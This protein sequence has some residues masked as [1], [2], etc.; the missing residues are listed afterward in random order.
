MS[1]QGGALLWKGNWAMRSQS[2]RISEDTGIVTSTV[3]FAIQNEWGVF[4]G[5][6][7]TVNPDTGVGSMNRGRASQAPWFFEGL[8]V[9]SDSDSYRFSRAQFSTCEYA[10]RD[11]HVSA[12][13]LEFHPEKWFSAW[14]NVLYL[15]PC[16]LFY[17]PYWRQSLSSNPNSRTSVSMDYDK[18]NGITVNTDT[19]IRLSS[20]VYD[21]FLADLYSRQGVGV[22]D[23]LDYNVKGLGRGTLYGY[24]V[25]EHL[26][27]RRRWTANSS[28]WMGLSR[29]YSL[30]WRLAAMSDPAFNTDYYRSNAAAV[31]AYLLNSAAVVRQSSTTTT[32]LSFS[33]QDNLNPAAPDH[34]IKGSEDYPRLDFNTSS[35]KLRHLPGLSQFTAFAD[36]NYTNGQGFIQDSAGGSWNWTGNLKLARG[37]T[38]APAGTLSETFQEHVSTFN[39]APGLPSHNVLFGRYGAAPDLRV[40]TG[41]GDWDLR[42]AYTCRLTPNRFTADTRAVDHGV[43]QNLASLSDSLRPWRAARLTVSSGYDLRQPPAGAPAPSLRERVLPLTANFNWQ[44]RSKVDISVSETYRMGFRPAEANQSTTL[45]ADYGEPGS[46]HVGLGFAKNSATPTQTQ[47][48]QSAGYWPRGLSWS[49]EASAHENL[50]AGAGSGPGLAKKIVSADARLRKN[51]HDFFGEVGVLYR[52][53]GV[54]QYS[55]DFHLR[56]REA[57]PKTIAHPDWE[58]EWYPWRNPLVPH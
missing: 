42:Y 8:R 9:D 52:P 54:L 7:G 50:G 43:E 57:A 33:R 4:S 35:L 24:Y 10:P 53:G 18:R 31:S 15:G 29:L 47:I 37:I 20:G 36:R 22:G 32:R 55:A 26:T 13:T 41:L 40:R 6:E 28:N 11:Y 51:W 34:F 3:P 58:K 23:E 49:L 46:N 2:L 17:F 14:N 38:L 25:P 12:T 27:G 1:L 56:F 21:H 5:V 39:G 45:Q 44:V 30:Q 48:S 16:P 19:S